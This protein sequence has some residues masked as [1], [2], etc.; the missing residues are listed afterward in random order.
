MNSL[1]VV[2]PLYFPT[3]NHE[4]VFF[5]RCMPS[6]SQQVFRDFELVL[7]ING[8]L[9]Y[10]A[11]IAGLVNRIGE[12]SSEFKNPIKIHHSP[13]PLGVSKAMNIGI[14]MSQGTHIA[15]HAQ[16]DESHPE[17]FLKQM[18]L[19]E[20]SP[21]ID[22]LGTGMVYGVEPKFSQRAGVGSSSSEIV[23]IMQ[24]WN[25]MVAGSCIVRRDMLATVNG[26]D[27]RLTINE[28]YEDWDLWKRIAKCGGVFVNMPDLLYTYHRD[29]SVF[30]HHRHTAMP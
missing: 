22:V 26:F 23:S 12:W 5:R 6:L 21:K 2:V 18:A 24:R 25:P 3:L 20:T 29:F 13:H 14:A 28:P 10:D 16:D 9:D 11:N 17:R 8:I 7:V 4:G 27:E 1:S 30:D 19:L 15:L